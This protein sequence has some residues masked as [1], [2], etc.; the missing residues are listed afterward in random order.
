ML[1]T[2]GK[3][4]ISSIKLLLETT[5]T[6]GN[7]FRIITAVPTIRTFVCGKPAATVTPCESHE[8]LDHPLN[9]LNHKPRSANNSPTINSR[10]DIAPGSH[11]GRCCHTIT[12][13]GFQYLHLTPPKPS[14]LKQGLKQRSCTVF[15]SPLIDTLIGILIGVMIPISL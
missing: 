2:V 6:P 3:R 15:S 11:S 9:P 10:G 5:T 14:P 7:Q 4:S 1:T 12:T 8:A 13:H